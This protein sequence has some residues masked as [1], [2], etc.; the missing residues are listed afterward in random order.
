MKHQMI[1]STEFHAKC[2]LKDSFK[3]TISPDKSTSGQS[4]TGEPRIGEASVVTESVLKPVSSQSNYAFRPLGSLRTGHSLLN[5]T[6]RLID[7]SSA[8][9]GRINCPDLKASPAVDIRTFVIKMLHGSN[10]DLPTVIL[11]THYLNKFISA[12]PF[13]QP[14]HQC[15]RRLFLA[16][17]IVAHKYLSENPLMNLIWAQRLNVNMQEINQYEVLLLNT[18]SHDMFISHEAFHDWALSIFENRS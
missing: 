17:V 8:L 13:P 4:S 10:I 7:F 15:G 9:I 14:K 18:I 1:D 16:S 3:P 5:Y 11:A 2:I 6:S 12:L